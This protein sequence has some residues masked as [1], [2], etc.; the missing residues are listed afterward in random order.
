MRELALQARLGHASRC[1][2]PPTPA[3]PTS[4]S[5]PS[6]STR[7]R[8]ADD[9]PGT[10]ARRAARSRGTGRRRAARHA[11]RENYRSLAPSPRQPGGAQ[12]PAGTAEVVNA[13]HM[14]LLLVRAGKV[15]ELDPRAD[16]AFGGLPGATYLLQGAA[17]TRRPA[18][19]AHRRD[20]GAQ[21]LPGPHPRPAKP[22][23]RPPPPGRQ[24][25][26]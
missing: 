8:A 17:G 1:R 11:D 4:G 7:C 3:C 13:G 15:S 6:T 26:H 20:A 2:P 24:C 18:G 14:P 9:R 23:Q 12:V 16:P 21:R 19:A 5:W 10:G 22:D 25:R